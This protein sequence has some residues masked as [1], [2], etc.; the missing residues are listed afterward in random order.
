MWMFFSISDRHVDLDRHLRAPGGPHGER[1]RERERERESEGVRER[2]RKQ[3]QVRN[4]S[5][6]EGE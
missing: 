6:D 1:E 3:K 4:L 5:Q 2:V